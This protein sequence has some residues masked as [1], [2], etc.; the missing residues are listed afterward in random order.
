[1]AFPKMFE[2]VYG[3]FPLPLRL[4]A[5]WAVVIVVWPLEI[6]GKDVNIVPQ[7]IPSSKSSLDVVQ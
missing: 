3:E 1:M 4:R 2:E 5:Q 7:A 6:I